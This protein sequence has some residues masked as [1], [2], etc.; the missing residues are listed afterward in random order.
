M[1]HSDYHL[2]HEQHHFDI[3]MLGAER[4]CAAIR[5]AHFTVDNYRDLISDIFDKTFDENA[6]LQE[7][8]DNQTEHSINKEIQYA[9]N[10]KINELMGRQD[11]IQTST[12]QSTSSPQVQVSSTHALHY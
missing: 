2:E 3:T 7:T 12:P 6:Q 4:F 5:E 9:W 8:Y 1:I 10:K 11:V